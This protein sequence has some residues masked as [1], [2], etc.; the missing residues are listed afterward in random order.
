MRL[1]RL[2]F[3]VIALLGTA[4]FIVTVALSVFY[5]H[6]IQPGTKFVINKFDVAEY[7]TAH[8]NSW[9]K[10][11]L[12]H[13]WHMERISDSQLRYRFFYSVSPVST[14]L[15]ALYI[16]VISQNAVAYLNG[17]EIG[18]GGS[19]V[20]PL[21]RN[22]PA[23]L[24]FPIAA[25]YL[26]K[27]ENELELRVFSEPA[28]RGLL[29]VFYFGKWSELISSYNDRRAL[30]QTSL[31]VFMVIL[32]SASF[33]LFFITWRR[34]DSSEYAW[35]GATFLGLSGRLLPVFFHKIPV[36]A[37]LW[38]W[39]QH[40][41][42]GFTVL[43]IMLFVN[44]YFKLRMPK[45]EISAI[46]FVIILS[47]SS[48]MFISSR[49]LQSLYFTYGAGVWGVCSLAIGVI[50]LTVALTNV[51]NKR[52]KP[53]LYILCV[54]GAMFALGFHDMLMVNGFITRENGYLLHYAS[55]L[56]ALLLTTILIT[57]L[58]ETSTDLEELNDSLEQRIA[59]SNSALA[60]SYE[61]V[62]KMEREKILAT[63]RERINRDMHDGL[64][65]HLSTA[66]ALAELDDGSNASLTQT[67][68]DATEE[69]RLMIDSAAV[70]GE[71]VGL[72]L[73][74]LRPKLQRQA[75]AADF[76]L[77]WRIQD[78]SPIDA[79]SH[80]AALSL[81]RIVQEAV[82]N[83]IKHSGGNLIRVSAKD[84]N[85]HVVV[86]I[87]DNGTCLN[88][89]GSEGGNGIPN[90]QKRAEELGAKVQLTHQSDFGGLSVMLSIP[91]AVS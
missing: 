13:D 11:N 60:A 39:W 16:P 26:V 71:D 7:S 82:T 69:L 73:G 18:N 2:A 8:G 34:T 65:G 38:D 57:R 15:Y 52:S 47:I 83:A 12:P 25:N 5:L 20:T 51:I 85:H 89:T 79:L 46:V 40:M 21:A 35:G 19:T 80:G 6:K 64:G 86:E 14:E 90:I 88:F 53:A 74:A 44:R 50:P 32:V 84:V 68:R 78:T 24:I 36:S 61:K 77:L 43:F 91:S 22:W 31:A 62:Q 54:G 29:P 55:P 42:M 70:L 67:I 23:P 30:K 75:E 45:L 3:S 1:S 10:T 17:T 41:C 9:E 56:V 72:L 49:E 27:G 4:C 66:L 48:F 76:Q 59:D 37:F 81:I 58:I 87:A 28:G 33:F 63:E